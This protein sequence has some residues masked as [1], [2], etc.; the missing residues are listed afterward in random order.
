LHLCNLAL[1][2][3]CADVLLRCAVLRRLCVDRCVMDGDLSVGA[4]SVAVR[5]STLG[6]LRLVQP[7]LLEALSLDGCALSAVWA[8][9]VV[10]WG[11]QA[12]AAVIADVE[13]PALA[14]LRVCRMRRVHEL[15]HT[16]TIRSPVRSPR[17][18]LVLVALRLTVC[19]FC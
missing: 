11:E 14:S 7:A 3:A 1:P 13:F 8:G 17:R 6:A 9:C 19:R 5:G 18:S 2:A 4:A 10:L 12:A 15:A 16:I